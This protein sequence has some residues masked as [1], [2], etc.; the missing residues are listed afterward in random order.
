MSAHQAVD[1][2]KFSPGSG[3]RGEAPKRLAWAAP[4]TPPGGDNALPNLPNSFITDN[5]QNVNTTQAGAGHFIAQ[6]MAAVWR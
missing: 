1:I 6:R 4:R 5:R 2:Q 3:I